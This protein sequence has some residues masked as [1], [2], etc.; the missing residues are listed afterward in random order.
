MDS[1]TFLYP[2][3][4]RWGR[5]VNK[6]LS[7]RLLLRGRRALL[8]RLPFLQLASEATDIVYCTW[9]IDLE[10]AANWI[11]AGVRLS[12][13]D[14]KILFTIL[15]YSHQHF[16]PRLAGPLRRF[17]PSP[18]QSNWRFYID[19]L[20]GNV[21][22]AGTVLFVKNIFDNALYAIGSR[23]FS[24]ALPSHLAQRFEHSVNDGLYHTTLRSGNGSAPDFHCQAQM[25]ANK[26]L[27]ATFTPFFDSWDAA[28]KFLC[29]QRGA[30][31]YVEDCERLAYAEIE[32]P[33][34][35]TSVIPLEVIPNT[36]SSPFLTQIGAVGKPLCFVVPRVEFR[37]LSEHLL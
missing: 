32:L 27:P 25:S 10:A 12:Q 36:I 20:P 9:V 1:N 4:G 28:V 21:T 7:N 13:H 11:P 34:D 19:T 3:S 30:V 5:L 2:K 17:F 18:R 33:I 8:S 15:T 14:G 16:G 23:L 6:L 24:D 29:L 37:V 31:S 35:V 22:H 26:H